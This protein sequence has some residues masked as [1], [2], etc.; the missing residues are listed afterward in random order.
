MAIV[1]VQEVIAV[2]ID[3]LD[4]TET[5]PTAARDVLGSLSHMTDTVYVSRQATG[6]TVSMKAS[7]TLQTLVDSS[8]E[9]KVN[10]S[11]LA[12]LSSVKHDYNPV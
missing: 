5:V 7:N 9:M 10:A 11:F 2:G 8:I 12:S 1:F 6:T 3:A 4:V